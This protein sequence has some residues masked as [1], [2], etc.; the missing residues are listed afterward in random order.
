LIKNILGA[1]VVG[2]DI[3]FGMA[4][5]EVVRNAHK[6]TH[7]H[8]YGSV[9]LYAVLVLLTLWVI[10]SVVRTVSGSAQAKAAAAKAAAPAQRPGYQY[11]PRL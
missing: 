1:A 9:A 11:G 10:V 8:L 4:V 3:L 2:A 5:P 7:A 6:E